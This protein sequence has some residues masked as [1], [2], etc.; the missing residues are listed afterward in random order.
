MDQANAARRHIETNVD[1][2][3]YLFT[4]GDVL[5]FSHAGTASV[6]LKCRL[7]KIA[8]GQD[9][10]VQIAALEHSPTPDALRDSIVGAPPGCVGN[11]CEPDE[12]PDG[13]TD[14]G[15]CEEARGGTGSLVAWF[16]G[17]SPY[18]A[19]TYYVYYLGGAYKLTPEGG[20][21]VEGYDLVTREADNAVRAIAMARRSVRAPRGGNRLFFFLARAVTP[22]PP[23]PR[24]SRP[25]RLATGRGRRGCPWP[26]AAPPA[27]RADARPVRRSVRRPSFA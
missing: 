27:G 14:P 8:E 18:A 12:D 4:P 6:R 16:N 24:R 10:L 9:K 20:Y 2:L 7:S 17:G 1:H 3:A 5:E 19:G 23:A 21:A 13:D 15:A 26:C 25:T 22:P 11:D